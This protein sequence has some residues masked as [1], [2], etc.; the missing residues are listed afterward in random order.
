M[1]YIFYAAVSH[2]ESIKD[3][4]GG[5]DSPWY[6]GSVLDH[7]SLKVVSFLTSSLPLKVARSI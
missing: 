5:G 1:Y 2:I 6:S 3:W 7:R 4:I